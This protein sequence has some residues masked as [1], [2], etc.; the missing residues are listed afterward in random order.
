MKKLT[1]IVLALMMIAMLC[2]CGS[3]NEGTNNNTTAANQ[4]NE[5]TQGTA[6]TDNTGSTVPTG[7]LFTYNNVQFGVDIRADEVLAKLGDYTDKATSASCAFGGDDTVYYYSSIQ[8]STNNE[9]G[10]DR[11]YSIYL[12]DD[13]VSTEEGICVGSTAEQVKA[14]YGDPT[15]EITTCLTYEKDGMALSFNLSDGVV[16]SILY[17]DI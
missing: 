3:S 5:N 11:I 4:T 2:A 1:L 16:S 13:L 9:L 8:V 14:A 17:N 15:E 6:P 10:Y 7:Y 12:E